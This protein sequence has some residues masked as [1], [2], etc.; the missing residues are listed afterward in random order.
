MKA[1]RHPRSAL[2][3]A[4]GLLVTGAFALLGSAPAFAYTHIYGSGAAL[5]SLLQTNILIPKSGQVGGFITFTA[6]SS[7]AGAK[8]FGNGTGKLSLTEDS[9]GADSASPAQLDAYVATDSG[10][11]TSELTEAQTAAG[12]ANEVAV[13]VAQTPLDLLLSL[14]AG[15]TV[16]AAQHIDLTA[17]LTGELYGG[18]VPADGGYSAYTWGAFLTEAGLT[19]ET[20]SSSPIVGQFYD[21]G[22]ASTPITI[23]VRKQGAGTTYNL[24]Q[25]LF[26]VDKEQNEGPWATPI[27]EDSNSYGTNEW[28]G[29]TTYL[30][31]ASPGNNTDNNEVEAVDGTPGTVGYATA[32][33]A[34]TATTAK[35]TNQP[36]FSTDPPKSGGTASASHQI[37]YALLQDNFGSRGA[38]IYADPEANI[39]G[40]A[41][42]YTGSNIDVNNNPAG[43]V[44]DWLVPNTGGTFSADDSWYGTR[45]SDPDVYDDS[46]DSI[47][48][49]PLVAVAFDL[50]WSDFAQVDGGADYDDVANA[51]QEQSTTEAFLSFATS[52]AGQNDILG[53]NFYAPLPSDVG[54][55]SLANIQAVANSA[56]SGV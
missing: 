38:P 26:L 53:E 20:G 52:N 6:T 17:Q 12:G 48:Y 19:A 27:I 44:G 16:N 5:Q 41:N 1:N 4:V 51:E 47:A 39:S 31:D 8:E 11:K 22:T 30:A 37:L 54:N 35:F 7:G 29:G 33:D 42:V 56:A 18:T 9:K 45:A 40:T 15:V 25:Y 50:S 36:L 2:L 24:K 21:S 14:P 46:G 13:P 55:S 49:Y 3:F 28:P 23:E 34:S 32:G 10:P 43:G